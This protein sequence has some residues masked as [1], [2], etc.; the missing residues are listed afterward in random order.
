MRLAVLGL[1]VI[2]LASYAIFWPFNG[3]TNDEW[4]YLY[5]G[6]QGQWNGVL[7]DRPGSMGAAVLSDWL[8]P[9][10]PQGIHWVYSLLMLAVALGLFQ[11]A[12]RLTGRL[13]AAFLYSAVY[14][15]YFPSNVEVGRAFFVQPY[16]WAL[17]LGVL[18][19]LLLV[20]ATLHGGGV[21]WAMAIGSV[22]VAVR[23]YEGFI[24]L[25]LALPALLWGLGIRPSQKVGLGLWVGAVSLGAL[26]FLQVLLGDGPSY[27]SSIQRSQ[28]LD[29]ALL[30]EASLDFMER[31]FPLDKLI[32]WPA[33]P[34]S[35]LGLLT[36]GL[37]VLLLR[38]IS[39]PAQKP[40]M[41][42][43]LLA[44]GVGGV[45]LT[46]LGGAAFIYAGLQQEPRAQFMA[47][48]GAAL[49]VTSIL[50]GVSQGLGRALR[51]QPGI[52]LGLL[53][54]LFFWQA[55]AWPAQAQ[56]FAVQERGPSYSAKSPF[57]AQLLG[58]M[59]QLDPDTLLIY[60]C[61]APQTAIQTAR[62]ADRYAVQYLYDPAPV[63][64]LAL[65]FHFTLLNPDEV[66][67][68]DQ[69]LQLRHQYDLLRGPDQR[70]TYAYA[71]MVVL[72][73][74]G[75]EGIYIE[76]AFPPDLAPPGADLSAYQ[77]YQRIQTGFITTS[78]GCMMAR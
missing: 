64:W 22:Y 72:G 17:A 15:G 10:R 54:G 48:P 45:A 39:V 5:A 23:V 6:Q 21:W 3:A 66:T 2:H 31:A 18:S 62:L 61:A 9:A 14:I 27:Q 78:A 16:A 11:V 24:P 20:E 40:L 47:A 71:Q 51:I 12:Y 67:W 44:V 42:R 38:R 43:G 65:P 59:P 46:W 49:L 35:W 69:G 63:Q 52:V 60:R 53:C 26:Q 68:T 57:L 1:V 37:V 73:C 4:S 34:P 70:L 19:L 55:S 25:L 50:L 33:M 32:T 41:L 30:R 74:D 75:L 76:A 36:A 8:F 29:V 7:I 28:G 77:P 13:E 56:R 58:W